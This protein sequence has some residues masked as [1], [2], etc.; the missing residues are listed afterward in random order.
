MINA[1][2]TEMS[3]AN[4]IAKQIGNKAFTMMGASNLVDTGEGLQFKIG[5]NPKSITHVTIKLEEASDTYKVEFIR[6]GRA[7][8]YKITTFGE[9]EDVHAGQLR[10]LIEQNTGLYLSL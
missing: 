3:I 5:R 1:R 4:E 9:F 8:S 7:P 2:E 6:L 10:E